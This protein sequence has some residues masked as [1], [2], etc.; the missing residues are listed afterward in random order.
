MFQRVAIA[1]A[2]A[3]GLTLVGAGNAAAHSELIASD[4]A[5]DA[6]VSAVPAAVT[7]TFNQNIESMF[8]TVVVQ[9]DG[10]KNWATAEPDV[11]GA[12]VR[13]AVD[14]AMPNGTYT[15][16]YRVVSADGHPITGSFQFT[17]AMNTGQAPPP[18]AASTPAPQ[19]V[20]DTPAPRPERPNTVMW[21]VAAATAGVL[22]GAAIVVGRG[23]IR[24]RPSR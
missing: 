13:A 19:T 6:T 20:T 11:S 22:V 14:G 17:I 12:Q 2:V 7:L 3:V 15:I 21:I 4:P 18:T 8:A 10:D 1:A 16:S 24:R 9:G 23:V 5:A